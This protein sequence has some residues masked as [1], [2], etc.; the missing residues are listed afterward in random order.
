M[1][2]WGS[3]GEA[4]RVDGR[5]D[6]GAGGRANKSLDLKSYGVVWRSCSGGEGGCL[7]LLPSS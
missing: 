2:R 5:E 3:L 6:E 7:P 1:V 4:G